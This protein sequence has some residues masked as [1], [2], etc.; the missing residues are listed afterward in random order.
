M[1]INDL[2]NNNTMDPKESSLILKMAICGA[3]YP[4]Y[5]LTHDINARKIEQELS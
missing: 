3:F 2:H 5:F 1:Y 4:N